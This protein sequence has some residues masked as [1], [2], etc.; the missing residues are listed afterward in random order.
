MSLTTSREILLSALQNAD[1]QAFYGLG[2]FT[3]PCA[4]IFAAEP[5]VDRSGLANGRRTQR[6]EIWAVAGRTDS[7]ATFDD[8]EKMVI[9]I[10]KVVEGLQGWSSCTWR[11]PAVTDMGGTKYFATRAVIE[12]TQEV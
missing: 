8:L 12:T 10:D 9:A 11:R 4:R 1:I 6:W 7:L 3:A 2:A 5:W